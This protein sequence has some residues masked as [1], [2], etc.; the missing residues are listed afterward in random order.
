MWAHP[1]ALPVPW[2][3]STSSVCTPLSAKLSVVRT[4]LLRSL[5]TKRAKLL[6]SSHPLQVRAVLIYST[7]C[8]CRR[9]NPHPCTLKTCTTCCV[10]VS[11]KVMYHVCLLPSEASL[12]STAGSGSL[13]GPQTPQSTSSS[14]AEGGDLKPPTPASTPHTQM[15]PNATRVQVTLVKH[16]WV[17]YRLILKGILIERN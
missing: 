16:L 4:L 11:L 1:A 10:W 12:C 8:S 17:L 3:S 7:P 5:T 9:S 2:R 14:M 13:Q 6:R 15:P